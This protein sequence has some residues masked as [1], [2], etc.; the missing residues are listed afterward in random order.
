MYFVEI[1]I[2]EEK[3]KRYIANDQILAELLKNCR[4][5]EYI[6]ILEEIKEIPKPKAKTKKKGT[7]NETNKH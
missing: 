6:K 7:N 4:Q 5:Y 3:I 2:G 1:K